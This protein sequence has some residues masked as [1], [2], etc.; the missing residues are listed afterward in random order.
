MNRFGG[1]IFDMDGLLLDSERIA[2]DAFNSACGEFGLGDQRAVFMRCVGAN[3]QRGEQIIREGLAGQ[4]DLLAFIASW[5]AQYAAHTEG[6]AIPVKAGAV[7]LL[8]AITQ[9]GLPVAVATSTATELAEAKLEAA[10][11]LQYF[12]HVVGGD[13]VAK[14]KPEPDIYLHAARLLE[15]RPGSA[16]ALEDSENGVLAAL[17]AG[18]T[19]IQIPDLVQPSAALLQRGHHVLASLED[20]PHHRF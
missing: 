9:L 16:L 10:G 13:Q 19:V 18:M 12:L 17:A 14:S 2:L 3:R 15:V 8:E 4:V 11:L 5:D 20:V 1:I 6:V 7:Q